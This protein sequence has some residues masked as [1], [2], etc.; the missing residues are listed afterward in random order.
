MQ[1]PED[2]F[3]TWRDGALVFVDG[4]VR[5]AAFVY[6]TADGLAWIEPSFADPFGAASSALH[7]RA[8][9]MEDEPGGGVRVGGLVV[10]PYQDDAD[11]VG[12]AL[13][14][15]ARW[16]AD[17]GEPWDVHRERMRPAP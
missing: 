5:P 8:G 7:F 3:A 15:F 16:V 4:L 11:L 12:D 17:S 10:L 14:W 6:Q 9:T 2:L 13:D 1:S